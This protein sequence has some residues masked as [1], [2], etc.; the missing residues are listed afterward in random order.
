MQHLDEGT[1][2]AWLDGALL[3]DESRRVEEHAATC[4]ACGA[5]VAEARGFIAAASRILTALDDVPAG[6][7]PVRAAGEPDVPDELAALRARKAAEGLTK[8]RRWLRMPFL[9]AA[10]MVFVAVGTLAVLQRGRPGLPT[11]SDATVPASA[12]NRVAAPSTPPAPRELPEA[13]VGGSAPVKETLRRERDALASSGQKDQE[14]RERKPASEPDV[15]SLAVAPAV[16]Q[17]A[18]PR[19]DAPVTSQPSSAPQSLSPQQVQEA[20]R[21]VGALA[22]DKRALAKVGDSVSKSLDSVASKQA[23]SVAGGARADVA[24]RANSPLRLNEVIVT[25][26]AT[27]PAIVPPPDIRTRAASLLAGCYQIDGAGRPLAIPSRIELDST[28]A[29][30]GADTVWYRARAIGEPGSALAA[31]RPELRWTISGSSTVD[32]TAK[33][34]A[35]TTVHVALATTGNAVATAA[36]SVTSRSVRSRDSAAEVRLTATPVACRR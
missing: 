23:S 1:I 27:I 17:R 22:D 2:H 28:V 3:P 35:L 5:L 15:T 14:S 31:S 25:G 36:P 32:I 7:T 18:A 19:R 34:V 16:Q 10:A 13:R 24:S 26:A 33:D 6:V 30:R 29:L 12:A 9:A 4:E 11:L 8:R 20:Q 21:Q